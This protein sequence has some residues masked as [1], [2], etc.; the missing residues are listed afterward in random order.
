MKG[1]GET[2]KFFGNVI[3]SI[4]MFKDSNIDKDMNEN[5]SKLEE[6]EVRKNE[7]IAAQLIGR[8]KVDVTPFIENLKTMDH[9]YNDPQVILFD[10]EKLYIA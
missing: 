3:K 8:Q 7:N 9:L 1:A 6:M 4:P 5:A 2:G 10:K